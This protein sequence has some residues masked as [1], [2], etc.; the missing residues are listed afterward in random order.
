MLE[1]RV[2]RRRFGLKTDDVIGD[3][4]KLHDEELHTLRQ[5]YLE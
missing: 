2:L 5:V 3:C 4:G 1:N